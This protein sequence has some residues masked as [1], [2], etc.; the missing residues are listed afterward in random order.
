M[1]GDY[2][3]IWIYEDGERVHHEISIPA[4]I[5]LYHELERLLAQQSL[6]LPE[7][8]ADRIRVLVQ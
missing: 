1:N 5:N 4:A 7:V 3:R 8:S 6:S 2:I